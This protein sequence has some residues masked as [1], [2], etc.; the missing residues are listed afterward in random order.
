MQSA[1]RFYQKHIIG[2]GG[3]SA[4]AT[5]IDVDI[6][7]DRLC[8]H[9]LQSLAALHIACQ[10]QFNDFGFAYNQI[11]KSKKETDFKT[12]IARQRV[13]AATLHGIADIFRNAA[14]LR[15][16]AYINDES[17]YNSAFVVVVFLLHILRDYR[18]GGAAAAAATNSCDWKPLHWAALVGRDTKTLPITDVQTIVHAMPQGS[19]SLLCGGDDGH[20]QSFFDNDHDDDDDDDSDFDVLADSVSIGASDKFD[21]AFSVGFEYMR[22]YYR[23]GCVDFAPVHLAVMAPHPYIDLL[24]LFALWLPRFAYC[25]TRHANALLQLM[26]L[27]CAAI[28]GTSASVFISLIQ[29]YPGA[30]SKT[31]PFDIVYNELYQSTRGSVSILHTLLRRAHF[32]DQAR[33]ID[34]LLSARPDLAKQSVCLPVTQ[35]VHET[36]ATAAAAAAELSCVSPLFLAC[37]RCDAYSHM[38]NII[39]RILDVH[40]DAARMN[41]LGMFPIHQ[42]CTWTVYNGGDEEDNAAAKAVFQGRILARLIAIFPAALRLMQNHFMLPVHLLAISEIATTHNLDIL[43]DAC[44]QTLTVP[45]GKTKLNILTLIAIHTQDIE[46]MAHIHQKNPLVV[47]LKFQATTNNDAKK[48][49]YA[50]LGDIARAQLSF[51]V[52][53][54][55]HAMYPD[56]VRMVDAGGNTVLHRFLQ[57]LR[58]FCTR[59]SHNH[60]YRDATIHKI[61]SFLLAQYPAAAAMRNNNGMAPLHYARTILELP[62]AHLRLLLRNAPHIDACLFRALNYTARR[63]A[64]FLAYVAVHADPHEPPTI[65]RQLAAIYSSSSSAMN[66]PLAHVFSFL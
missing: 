16:S 13:F 7:I 33:M 54:A 34:A 55:V 12:F 63:G 46:I 22:L 6:D 28:F 10:D 52:F 57:S 41:S 3:A 40:P 39:E 21:A 64:L 1:R 24:N 4:A 29:A 20:K 14:D 66:T 25:R 19:L 8:V 5:D 36:V 62:T 42:V 38:A 45:A 37:E 17:P 11:P 9:T 23:R 30:I 60:S 26:P 51:P 56:A 53:K 44:P 65:L 43:I 2:G 48:K 15:S 49:E 58:P 61:L 35:I 27:Q 59:Y 32:P 47:F 31:V 50:L 18:G